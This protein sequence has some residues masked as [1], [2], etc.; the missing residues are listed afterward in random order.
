MIF[1]DAHAANANTSGVT[2]CGRRTGFRE[3]QVLERHIWCKTNITARGG[4]KRG[5]YHSQQSVHAVTYPRIPTCLNRS[6]I[7]GTSLAGG[8][9]DKNI[10]LTVG[11]YAEKADGKNN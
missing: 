8:V 4:R 11:D 1:R 6:F 2:G 3:A 5:L 10:N 9:W 7:R